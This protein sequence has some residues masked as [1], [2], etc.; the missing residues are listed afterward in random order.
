MKALNKQL[1]G[2]KNLV[3]LDF[4]GTQFSHEIIAI[5]AVKCKIDENGKIID[6]DQ[7]GFLKYVRP[8]NSIGS[9]ISSLTNL[10]EEFIKENG[11]DFETALEDLKDYV[12]VNLNDV[13]FIVFG[14]NDAKM[15]IES[16]KYSRP[17]NYHICSQIL[18]NIFDFLAFISQYIRDDNN[19]TYSLINYLGLYDKKPYGIPHNPLNDAIDLKNLYI[20][21]L[22]NKN[23]AK[24]EY[25]KILLNS[26][27]SPEP[28]KRI[29]EKLQNN[30]I[31][32]RADFEQFI[33][34][35]LA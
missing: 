21:F 9:I 13:V 33:D 25:Q 6:E 29:L 14:S 19:N 1:Q 20:A 28:I 31:V 18:N 4:E 7:N 27:L 32:T 15:I 11:I 17:V 16:E 35:Y 22:E 5:G 12:G 8:K 34:D 24:K 26:K 30:E 2:K 23:I 10:T 3:F